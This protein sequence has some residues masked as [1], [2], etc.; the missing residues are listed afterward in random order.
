MRFNQPIARTA[1][2][3]LHHHA[4]IARLFRRRARAAHLFRRP[5]VVQRRPVRRA[6]DLGLG[7]RRP[8]RTHT[9]AHARTHARTEHTSQPST[10]TKSRHAV[11]SLSPSPRR[12]SSTQPRV[13]RSPT[14]RC[15]PHRRRRRLA[16]LDATSPARAQRPRRRHGWHR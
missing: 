10:R 14:A 12:C 8:H 1:L 6:L 11:T 9:H 4:L 16:S 13:R 2:L 7:R 5:I 3:P 15:A